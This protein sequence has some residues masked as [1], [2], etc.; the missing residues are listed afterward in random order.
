MR[1]A[2]DLVLLSACETARDQVAE[3]EGLLGLAPA[4]LM[5]GSP[6]VVAGLWKVDDEATKALMD[7]FY[8]SWDEGTS[9]A[10]SLRAAQAAVRAVPKWSHPRFWAPWVVWGLPD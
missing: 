10:G 7:A 2:S 9:A 3:G 5:A 1:I 4:F 6:R 8:A